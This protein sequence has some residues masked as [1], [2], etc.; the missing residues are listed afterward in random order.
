M[1]RKQFPAIITISHTWLRQAGECAAGLPDGSWPPARPLP[2]ET[3]FG[4]WK[5]A[6]LVFT[7]RADALVWP[8]Q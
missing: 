6:W 2:Y 1:R 4:R 8:G 5:A 7:G 3:M